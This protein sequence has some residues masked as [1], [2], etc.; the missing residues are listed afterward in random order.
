MMD[1]VNS[2]K[3]PNIVI[4]AIELG[5]VPLDALSVTD[6][7]SVSARLESLESSVQTVISAVGK[8]TAASSPAGAGCSVPMPGVAITPAPAVAPSYV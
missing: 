1:M 5:K 8:L 2:K 3:V 4:P 6:E 7:R